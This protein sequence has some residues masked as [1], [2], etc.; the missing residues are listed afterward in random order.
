[1]KETFG[2][3]I[4]RL[5]FNNGLTLTKLAAALDIDQSTLSKIENGKRSVP[6]EI[7]PK[8]STVFNIELKHLEQEYFSE[9][10][11]EIIYPQDEPSLILK[12]AEEKAKYL[13][14]KNQKQG[15]LNF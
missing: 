11:A 14:I 5:R 10:I 7:L 9:K 12:A 4:H 15:K 8:L 6:L 3:Y 2:E 1:M 13:R